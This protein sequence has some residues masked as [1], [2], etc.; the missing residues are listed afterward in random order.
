MYLSPPSSCYQRISRSL[1]F[2][3]YPNPTITPDCIRQA[4]PASF[5]KSQMLSKFQNTLYTL[6]RC[7]LCLGTN[8]LSR[9]N[10]GR[11]KEEETTK[12]FLLK[13]E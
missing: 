11:E 10:N 5:G 9:Y 13:D 3:S 12:E 4:S 8:L 1:V 6:N 7:G 2:T